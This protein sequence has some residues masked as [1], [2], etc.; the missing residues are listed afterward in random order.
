MIEQNFTFYSARHKL[1]LRIDMI[2]LSASLIL[3]IGEVEIG[4]RSLSD[5]APVSFEW[6]TGVQTRGKRSRRLNNFLLEALGAEE[7]NEQR[8]HRL[9][10]VE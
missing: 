3:E 4:N 6:T 5:H 1:F 10:S 8:H 2:F 9:L 7:K